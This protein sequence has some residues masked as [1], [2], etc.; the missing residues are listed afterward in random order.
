MRLIRQPAVLIAGSI[1]AIL[2]LYFLL[3][4]DRAL[5]L[6][7]TPDAIARA[8]G[9]GMFILPALGVWWLVHEWRLGVTVQRME[10]RLDAEGRLPVDDSETLASG[11]LTDEAASAVFARAQRLVDESPDD[12]AAWFGIANAYDANRDRPMA[13]RAMRHAAELFRADR[14]RRTAAR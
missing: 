6:L 12:W 5:I 4:A 7:R 14:A 10:D 2:L 9:V 3:V 13:R 8:F 1:S 11:R